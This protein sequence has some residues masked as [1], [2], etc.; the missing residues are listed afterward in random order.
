MAFSLRSRYILLPLT[1]GLITLTLFTLHFSYGPIRA[2]SPLVPSIR[3]PPPP[4]DDKPKLKPHPLYKSKE[5]NPIPPPLPEY[6]PLAASAKSPADLPPVPSWNKPPQPHV[7]E[8]TRLY[9]GFTR[10]WPLLQQVVISYIT[11]GWPPEDIYVVE[12]TGTFDANKNGLLTSQNPFYLDYH[13]LTKILGVNVMT[14]PSLQTFAQL[15]NLYLSEAI[16]N[17]LSYYFWAH[18]DTVAQTHEDAKPYKSLYQIAV[19]TI[20]ESVAPEF[21]QKE[22]RWAIRFFAYDWL[23]LVNVA[24]YIEVGAWDSMI[25]Y[26]GTDCDMHNRLGMKGLKTPLADA[27]KVYDVG[28]SLPDLEVLYRRKRKAATAKRE[29]KITGS[30]GDQGTKVVETG[31]DGSRKI[32]YKNSGA[33]TAGST[34]DEGTKE[35]KTSNGGVTQL[36]NNKTEEKITG[37]TLDDGKQAVSVG[38]DGKVTFGGTT[39]TTAEADATT[40]ADQPATSIADKSVPSNSATPAAPDAGKTAAETPLIATVEANKK[41]LAETEEDLPGSDTWKKLQDTLE[42]MDQEKKHDPYR[43]SW[44][45]KQR[46]GQGEPFHYDADGWEKALQMTIEAGGRIMEEKWGHKGC[47][48]VQAGLKEGDQWR[49]EHDW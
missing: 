27:G 49:V 28:K 38:E 31:P 35:D 34:S 10:Y 7:P 12:N 41:Y 6:F 32:T 20:R 9:I 23:A 8:K 46:G 45:L 22:G 5:N 13:R 14:T 30:T 37:S 43:N 44:Q 47:D 40:V 26:Y 4:A 24:A 42:A 48:I 16:N 21:E 33:K 3:P 19:D 36:A 15:Q 11:A 25:G 2:L 39:N 17:N 29:E 1:L 18:M